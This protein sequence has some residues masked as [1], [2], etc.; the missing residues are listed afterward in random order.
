MISP[1]LSEFAAVIKAICDTYC[2]KQENLC[3]FGY[4]PSL[5][6]QQSGEKVRRVRQ[7]PLKIALNPIFAP[8]SELP[9]GADPLQIDYT[10]MPTPSAH[11]PREMGL[12]EFKVESRGKWIRFWRMRSMLDSGMLGPLLFVVERKNL[13][14]FYRACIKLDRHV[15]QVDPPILKKGMLEDI[16]SNSIGFLEDA[17]INRD[18]YKEFKIPCKRGILLAGRPG[19]GK[20]MTCK[21]LRHACNER[22]FDYRII[23]MEEYR[24]AYNRGHVHSLFHLSSHNDR[25]IIFFDDMDIMF[26][27]RSKGNTHLTEFLTNLDGIEP[28]EGVVFIFTSNKTEGLD[29]AFIRPGRVDVV[30]VFDAPNKALRRRFITERFHPVLL[31]RKSVV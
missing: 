26:E 28:N 14:E 22:S 1:P 9:P 13:R 29:G 4:I 15:S 3:K 7:I 2:L 16:W 8:D 21:Y 20:T 5:C 31:D 10:W 17:D 25:G 24:H 27:D 23:T 18:K 12:Y 30:M 6:T 11:D 19:C